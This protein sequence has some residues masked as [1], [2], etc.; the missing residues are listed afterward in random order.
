LTTPAPTSPNAVSVAFI[1]HA[2]ALLLGEYLPKIE[3]CLGRLTDEQVWWRAN[4]ESNSIGNLLLHLSGNVRQWIS[5]GLGAKPDH[6]ERDLEFSERDIITREALLTKLRET[7]NEADSVLSEFDQ[8]RLLDNYKIQSS[9]VTALEAIFHV[10]EH[11]SMHTG[12]ILYIT[13]L[14]TSSD[15]RFYKFDTGRPIRHW[16]S[17]TS[18]EGDS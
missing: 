4:E 13:K 1:D 12:Q 17:P 18:S 6:R 7:L 9:E 3:R 14:L 5:S 11:F 16:A 15:L 2:R 8:S 10:T